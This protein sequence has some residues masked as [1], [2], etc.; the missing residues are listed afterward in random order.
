MLNE[1]VPTFMAT[2]LQYYRNSIHWTCD[3]VLTLAYLRTQSS[4]YIQLSHYEKY[5]N[6]DVIEGLLTQSISFAPVIDYVNINPSV[7]DY[8]KNR[9]LASRDVYAKARLYIEYKD[10]DLLENI[11][12]AYDPSN[13]QHLKTIIWQCSIDILGE[14]Y[15]K[16]LVEFIFTTVSPTEANI[17]V[18]YEFLNYAQ[19]RI[20]SDIDLKRV[21]IDKLIETDQ[22]HLGLIYITNYG[23]DDRVVNWLSGKPIDTIIP[24]IKPLDP[25]Q[26]VRNGCCVIKA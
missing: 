23:W 20:I 9:I 12:Q 15:I 11:K 1:Y 17:H 22:Y 24:Y 26:D 14:E 10:R 4:P 3:M 8:V 25:D 16:E 19:Q 7:Y 21:F 5:H 2:L 6:D 13:V 18:L